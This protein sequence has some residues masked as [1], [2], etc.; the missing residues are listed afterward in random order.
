MK[1][2]LYRKKL[3]IKTV[4]ILTAILLLW[5][6]VVM[7]FDIPETILPSP[8][9]ALAH[10]FLT[11]P[12]ANYR[13]GRHIFA[14]LTAVG[15]GFVITA[16]F[17]I[18]IAVVIAWFSTLNRILMPAFIFIN[19]LPIIAIAPILLIWFGYGLFTN[20]LI[21]FLIAFFPVV[22]NT[23]KGL[24]DV[25]PDL[26]DLVQY[27]NAKKMIVFLKIR[28][29]NSLPFMFAGLKVSATLVVVGAI[30]GEF[31]AS[32][33]GLGYIIIN[34]QYSMDTAPVFSSLIVISFIGIGLFSLVALVEKV[35]MPWRR[36]TTD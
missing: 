10:L 36:E 19:S 23:L 35:L 30:V 1:H 18:I 12:D 15:T 13:W 9:S 11:Q 4:G 2:R 8:V 27:M 31:I 20:V 22:I 17:S 25:D 16:L 6:L 28:I 34:S 32:D 33:R 5:Q 29:P 7:L 3:N 26:L 24:N 14:T 21:A